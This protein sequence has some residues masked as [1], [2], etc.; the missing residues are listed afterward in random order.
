MERIY[1]VDKI[2]KSGRY[3]FQT[4]GKPKKLLKFWKKLQKKGV[5]HTKR[6]RKDADKLSGNN[7]YIQVEML[8]NGLE[9]WIYHTE[10]YD[11]VW[12]NAY[13]GKKLYDF[14]NFS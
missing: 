7:C 13:K 14:Y 9:A 3:A 4:Y 5:S 6:L 1:K 12:K 10:S 2:R 8:I 11:K